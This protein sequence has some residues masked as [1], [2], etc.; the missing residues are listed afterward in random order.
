MVLE[1]N[2]SQVLWYL[3]ALGSAHMDL[4]LSDFLEGHFL[5]EEVEIIKKV[6]NHL[7]NLR[8]WDWASIPWKGSPSSRTRSL[9]RPVDF[10]GPLFTPLGSGLLPP[11]MRQFLTTL[12]PSP[13]LWTK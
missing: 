12:E 2:L 3:Q 6:G 10:E 9:Q 8:R 4:Y 11:D 5:D 13:N 1:K 7:T